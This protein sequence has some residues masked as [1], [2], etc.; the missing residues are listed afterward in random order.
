MAD[1]LS[2]TVPG[3]ET[4]VATPV[5]AEPVIDPATGEPSLA[6]PDAAATPV[7]APVVAAPVVAPV[8]PDKDSVALAAAARASYEARTAKKALADAQKEIDALKANGGSTASAQAEL[9]AIKKDPSL[10]FKHGWDAD[11]L[12]KKILDPSSQESPADIEARIEAKLQARIDAALK[13]K[14]K[15]PEEI[16]SEES[17]AAA[18]TERGM[19]QATE[20]T[21]NLIKEQSE[22]CF[23]VDADDARGIVE[24]VV[25]FCQK[26]KFEPTPEQGKALVLQGIKGLHDKRM[27]REFAKRNARAVSN[28]QTPS[29]N[30]GIDFTA[31]ASK[32]QYRIEPKPTAPQTPQS[33]GHPLPTRKTAFELGFTGE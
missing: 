27:N 26:E 30:E 6:P 14:E 20:R 16:A 31:G 21:A 12:M 22:E 1:E 11:K 8:V 17:A 32:P 7:V 18:A 19:I 5:V 29:S 23:W 28:A 4:P 24:Q 10:L 3:S 2:F 13:P 15:T 33:N 9:D 25:K